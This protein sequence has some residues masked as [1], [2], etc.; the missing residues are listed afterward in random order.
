MCSGGLGMSRVSGEGV[1][2]MTYEAKVSDLRSEGRTRLTFE[3]IA[4]KI[5]LK[6]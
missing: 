3:N 4:S 2:K 5:T 1:A 6:S